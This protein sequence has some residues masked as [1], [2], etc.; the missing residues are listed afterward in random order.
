MA[1]VT[2]EATRP[3]RGQARAD[4]D[5]VVIGAGFASSWPRA[6]SAARGSA[7]SCWRPATVS[8]GRTSTDRRFGHDLEIGGTWM[9]W[10]QPHT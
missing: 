4:A 9:H 6:N 3:R 1:A 7:C 2:P 8:G 5:V 10:V